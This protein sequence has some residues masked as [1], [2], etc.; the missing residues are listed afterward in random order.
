MVVCFLLNWTID[1]WVMEK[2]YVPKVV[3][4]AYI[5]EGF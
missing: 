1:F 3:N 4:S 2:L 5:F